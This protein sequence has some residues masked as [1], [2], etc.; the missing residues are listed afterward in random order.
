MSY[1]GA[2]QFVL[3]AFYYVCGD[4]Y[5]HDTSTP[6]ATCVIQQLTFFL[7]SQ[8]A[9]S[10]DVAPPSLYGFCPKQKVLQK[11][12]NYSRICQHRT[13][14]EQSESSHAVCYYRAAQSWALDDSG[15]WRLIFWILGM[16][17]AS[18]HPSGTKKFLGFFF[19]VH[20]SVHRK[21]VSKVQPTRRN[22]FSIYLFL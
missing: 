19:Y 7:T 21:Y 3:F 8:Q 12:A 17:L 9:L 22:V 15:N 6:H 10:A 20:M 2:S 16:E 5:V 1:L 14:F 13:V 4:G 11:T 18:H